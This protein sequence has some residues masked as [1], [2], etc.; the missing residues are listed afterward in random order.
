M[1]LGWRRA[2]CTSIPRDRD[3]KEKQDS[4]NPTP[5]PRISSKFG[6]FSNP[7]TPRFQSPPVSS[8]ILRCR[9]TAAPPST[10]TIQAASAPGSPKLQCKTKNSPRFFNSSTPSSPRSP[11]TFS[12]LKSSLGFPKQ[13]KCGT[14]LQ[15]V[16]TGQ[17]TAIF[18]AECSHSFHFP[19]IAAL[20][21]KQ[22]ALVC[23][24]CHSEW[25]ELPLLSIHD[26]QKPVKVEEK[27]IREV[28][29]SPKAKRDVKFTNESSFQGRPILKV[30]ND[31]EPLMSPTSGARFN[32]IPESDE[33]DEEEDNVVEEFQGFFV[34]ANVKPV[35]ESLVNFTNFEL[36][37][38]PEAAVVSVGR[39]H[40]TYVIILK[41]KAP[42]ALARTARRAP[43]DLVMVL[44][45]SAKMKPQNIQMMK[46]AMRLVISSLSSSDRLSI[47]AFSTTSKR[48][49][50]LR[51]MT[52]SGKRSARRI[53]DAI[54]ALDGTGTSAS[55]AL[56]KAAKVLED[57]RERNPVA[58]IML[59]SDNPNQ[60]STATTTIS[61]NQRYQ[62]SIVST[63]TRF[64][65][66]EIP[67]HSIGLNQSNEETFTKFIGRKLNFVVQDLKVQLG[68]VSGSAPAEVAAVYSYT[69]R[70][71][72]LGSGSLRLGDFYAEEERELLVELKV[73]TSVIGA[74]HVLSV[75]CSYKDPSTE[76]LVYCKEQA[77]LVPRPHAV[78]SSTPNIQRLRD[79]FISTRAVAESRRMIERNDLTGA[80]H[81]LSSARALLIQSN[82]SSTR[83]FLPGLETELSELHYKRHNQAQFQSQFQSQPQRPHRRR[84]D[85]QQREDDKAEPLTPTSA[86]RAA[87]RL[88]KVA[89]MRKSLNRVSDLHGFEDARF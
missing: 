14:C 57:R 25:K 52:S 73:P 64:N 20:L 76:E 22:T 84:I 39:S 60:R 21:R 13:T 30:Y 36:R 53:V 2:F 77:L 59:L 45:V 5:S 40:E 72:S 75:R 37:L 65:N 27:T 16:K 32:P 38:L 66:L 89:I 10:S 48:L 62:S 49:L 44:D 61:T 87:E 55:D 18:T 15:T 83:E 3:T 1:V 33:Y 26:T 47:V 41:L 78:R 4:T 12:L 43:I 8:S 69:N 81:L 24:V 28:S 74:H 82:S 51:R 6:F 58:S 63:C 68:F 34:D 67:V 11:S 7:S 17:G 46:R 80:H 70:P 31:D 79:L 54:V 19:C 88:A 71:A 35:K 23:P 9:T 50:P 56:K 29:P 85:V 86:W 42:P